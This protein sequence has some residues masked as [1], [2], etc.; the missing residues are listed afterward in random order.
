MMNDT[1]ETKHSKMTGEQSLDVLAQLFKEQLRLLGRLLVVL[2]NMRPA[3]RPSPAPE[4]M[5]ELDD[6]EV[7]ATD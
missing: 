2:R 1:A 7:A 5:L 6:E 3:S 4:L